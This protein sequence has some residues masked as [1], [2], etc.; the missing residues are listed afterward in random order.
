[1]GNSWRGWAKFTELFCQWDISIWM[2]VLYEPDYVGSA[3][4]L[5]VEFYKYAY[6]LCLLFY[7]AMDLT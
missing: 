5:E 3:E 7:V 2:V 1:M 4:W 6:N